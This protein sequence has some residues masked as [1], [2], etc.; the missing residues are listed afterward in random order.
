MKNTAI[1]TLSSLLLFTGCGGES[2]GGKIR[3]AFGGGPVGGAFQTFS[4]SMALI[5][6]KTDPKLDI[7]A[8]GTGGSGANLRG[9]NAGDFQYG[10]S[11]AG[12]IYLGRRGLL[13]KDT[14]KY[15]AVQPVG[16]LYGGVAHLVVSEKSGIQ[17]VSDLPG[18][19]LAL[20]NAGSGAALSASRYFNALGLYDK[21][22]VEFL[23]Y[24]QAAE[25]LR[26]GKLDGFWV[27]SAFPNAAVTQAASSIKIR[28]I[29]LHTPA[30]E[31]P[32]FG[33]QYP[34]YTKSLLKGGHYPGIDQDVPS[35]Q[36]TAYLTANADVPA[37][38]VYAAA[39]A[40]YSEEGL[41]RMR[42]SHPAA[43]EMSV[44]SLFTGLPAPAHPGVLRFAKEMGLQVPDVR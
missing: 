5:T 20:G 34:F 4:N 11:Y 42:Q 27:L 16:A 29:D 8:E 6:A 33:E 23:G 19:R 38:L 22:Q 37:D 10:I 14:K 32:K 28:L 15:T 43:N 1:L 9:V 36:D 13:P 40:I 18:K 30:Q 26:D 25:A 44:Q 31:N 12:D 2:S 35:F 7:A 24:S 41:K 3:Q 39:K 17:S 21:M